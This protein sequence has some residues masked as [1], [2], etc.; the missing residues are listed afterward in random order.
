MPRLVRVRMPAE[1]PATSDPP[2][3]VV[4][5]ALAAVAARVV[6]RRVRVRRGCTG[7]VTRVTGRGMTIM[8]TGVTAADLDW[9]EE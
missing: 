6:G 9:L 7:T 1:L 2:A 3:A 8:I 5:R 4:S